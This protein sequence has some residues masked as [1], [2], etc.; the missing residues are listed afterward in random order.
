MDMMFLA[1]M[2]CALQSAVNNEENAGNDEI[3]GWSDK[4]VEALMETWKKH[5]LKFES[6]KYTK[7]SVG[8]DEK[9][10]N[11]KKSYDKIKTENNKTGN[12]PHHWK[13]YDRMEEILKRSPQFH[14]VCIKEIIMNQKTRM[15]AIK[16]KKKQ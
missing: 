16:R 1:K 2:V 12:R 6:P 14:P 9:W 13:F 4:E 15:L 8:C 3:R 10:R 11:L 5:C 7:K